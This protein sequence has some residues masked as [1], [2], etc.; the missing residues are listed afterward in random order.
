MAFCGIFSAIYCLNCCH[1]LTIR[2]SLLWLFVGN[3]FGAH[4]ASYLTFSL[5]GTKALATIAGCGMADAARQTP[6]QHPERKNIM[7]F[8]NLGDETE[9]EDEEFRCFLERWDIKLNVERR[10]GSHSFD[11]YLSN[12]ALRD[13][14]S[15][16]LDSLGNK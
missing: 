10:P 9:H 6:L 7:V 13:A 11:D 15:F 5:A 2:D 12:G 4:L 3:S 1:E 14:F 8:S 16:C